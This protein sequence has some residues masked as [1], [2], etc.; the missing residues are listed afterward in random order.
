MWSRFWT[1][2]I[3]LAANNSNAQPVEPATRFPRI[4]GV[5]THLSFD[6]TKTGRM[7]VNRQLL[8]TTDGGESWTRAVADAYLVLSR[9]QASLTQ[10]GWLGWSPHKERGPGSSVEFWQLD[11]RH[12]VEARGA[13]LYVTSDS[14]RSWKDA[15]F[16]ASCAEAGYSGTATLYFR[17]ALG[18]LRFTS[19]HFYTSSDHGATW[20]SS[21]ID[22]TSKPDWGMHPNEPFVMLTDWYGY[23]TRGGNTIYETRDAGKNWRPLFTGNKENFHAIACYASDCWAAASEGRLLH[24]NAASALH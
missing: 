10:P 21:N 3:L 18:L 22:D 8:V 17:G 2:L 12:G 14:G 20:C 6:S 23:M 11:A 4:P 1:A 15:A 13:K 9:S 19:G 16:P 7:V 24:W 5:V